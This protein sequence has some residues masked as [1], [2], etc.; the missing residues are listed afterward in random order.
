MDKFIGFDIHNG[1]TPYVSLLLLL[2]LPMPM[3]C[4]LLSGGEEAGSVGAEPPQV[5]DRTSELNRY[6]TV[7]SG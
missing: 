1:T 4:P 2:I 7:I 6:Q 5:I 3:C